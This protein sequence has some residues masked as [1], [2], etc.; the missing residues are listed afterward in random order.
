[1]TDAHGSHFR[2]NIAPH[3]LYVVIAVWLMPALALYPYLAQVLCDLLRYA[4]ELV[5]IA[6]G[7]ARLPWL[8]PL[9]RF[10]CHVAFCF[11]CLPTEYRKDPA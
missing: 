3:I 11:R 9:V 1:M 2:P 5:P 4:Y 6:T 7:R 8:R 10:L